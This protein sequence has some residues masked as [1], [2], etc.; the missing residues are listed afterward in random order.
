MILR[1]RGGGMDNIIKIPRTGGRGGKRFEN[2]P[3]EIPFQIPTTFLL[4]NNYQGDIFCLLQLKHN[5]FLLM[6]K[7]KAITLINALSLINK[8]S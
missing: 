8:Y 2:Q 4:T 5:N 1:K 7:F 6:E 3:V